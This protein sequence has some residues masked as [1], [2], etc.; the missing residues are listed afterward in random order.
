M[1]YIKSINISNFRRYFN[2][3][4][5]F[6]PRINIIVGANASG[7]TSIVEAIG[8]TLIGKSFKN[9]K[10]K[11]VIN[12]Q[13]NYFSVISNVSNSNKE[14]KIVVYQD[15]EGKKVS[16]NGKQYSKISDFVGETGLIS[17]SPD[18]LKIIKGSPVDRR[19]YLDSCICQLDNNYLIELANYNKLIKQRN[20]YLKTLTETTENLTFLD[21]IDEKIIEIGKQI[22]LKR[23]D[24]INSITQKANNLVN[25]LSNNVDSLEISYLFKVNYE[26]YE[27]EFK[28]RRNHDIYMQTTTGGPHRDDLLITINNK[29]ATECASQGQIRSAVIALKMSFYE[30]FKELNKPALIIMDDVLSELDE[31]RQNEVLK[32]LDNENQIFITCTNI[33]LLNQEIIDKSNVIHIGKE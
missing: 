8:Y 16:K 31:N 30:L 32:M 29:N 7:K 24:F 3:K 9:S 5:A 26:N 11:E 33:N 13:C 6:E 25:K 20:E 15:N 10:D 17:F 4:I 12:D 27:K 2:E 1:Y 19:K 21:V 28:N 14:E 22:V 23:N 18:D